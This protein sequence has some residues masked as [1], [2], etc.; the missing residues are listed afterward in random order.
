MREVPTRISIVRMALH[1]LARRA[2]F[3]GAV[4][5]TAAA[6]GAAGPCRGIALSA[7]ASEPSDASLGA[8]WGQAVDGMISVPEA[9]ARGL[10]SRDDVLYIAPSTSNSKLCTEW[11]PVFKDGVVL[12]LTAWNP[13]GVDHPLDVNREANARL[14]HDLKH[15]VPGARTHTNLRPHRTHLWPCLSIGL[16]L[17]RSTHSNVEI[18]WLQ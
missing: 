9:K 8:T 5:I 10:A 11:P 3:G 14:H 13:M 18:I 1:C 4:T 15:I 7:A 2:A 12:S 6:L 17:L 16:L